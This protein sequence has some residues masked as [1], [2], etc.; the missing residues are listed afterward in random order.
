MSFFD[1]SDR[2]DIKVESMNREHRHLLQI[3]NRLFDASEASSP[4]K[5]NKSQD[6]DLVM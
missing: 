1:W 6:R 4:T 5:R 2:L 3:M